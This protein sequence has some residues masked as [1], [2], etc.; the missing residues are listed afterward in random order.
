MINENSI[1]Y[2]NDR[3]T[4]D[5][6]KTKD[7]SASQKDKIRNH[8]SKAE[9]LLT[10]K[11]FAMFVH[12]FKFEVI[13]QLSNIRGHTPEENQLRIALSN[14]LTGIDNFINT[15]KRAVFYKNKIG[16]SDIDEA[17]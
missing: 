12:Q 6:T 15:L 17:Q 9:N 16:N 5:Y 1:E 4:F 13:D 14:E 11:D 7:L 2:F 8:G 3:L 10:N